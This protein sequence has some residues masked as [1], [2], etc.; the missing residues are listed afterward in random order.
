MKSEYWFYLVND[1]GC[2]MDTRRDSSVIKARK[3]FYNTFEGN[4]KIQWTDKNGVGK[5]K[6]VRL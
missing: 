1:E 3:H 4:Y 5:E 6:N 2:V